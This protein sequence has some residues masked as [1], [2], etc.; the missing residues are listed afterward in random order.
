MAGAL[1]HHQAAELQGCREGA[2]EPLTTLCVCVRVLVL[3]WDA[4]TPGPKSP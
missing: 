1:L 4:G 3:P 2:E